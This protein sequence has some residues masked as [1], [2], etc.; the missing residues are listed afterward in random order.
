MQQP[1]LFDFTTQLATSLN[2]RHQT[3]MIKKPSLL[4]S[5]TTTLFVYKLQLSLLNVTLERLAVII[6][7]ILV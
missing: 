2:L 4:M 5:R 3:E 7:Y 6:K 1:T